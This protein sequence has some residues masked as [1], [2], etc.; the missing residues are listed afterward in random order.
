MT[1]DEVRDRVI[2]EIAED[3]NS[4]TRPS[5][6]RC[7]SVTRCSCLP[8]RSPPVVVAGQANLI[9][10]VQPDRMRDLLRTLEDKETLVRLLD[11]TR[12]AE[13]LQVFLGAETAMQ[14]LRAAR[15]SR[16]P[17]VP[18]RRRSARSR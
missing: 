8:E 11:R 17:T 4:T 16:C 7:A 3:K 6:P 18:R 1:I 15:S 14:A 13:G 9:D 2:R 10:D 12:H 5:R